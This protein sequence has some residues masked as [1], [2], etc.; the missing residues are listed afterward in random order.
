[1][2]KLEETSVFLGKKLGNQD[3][4][5]RAP[6]EIIAKE[7]EKYDDCIKKMERLKENLQKMLDLKGG[8]P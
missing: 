3:F 2:T 8:Q 6:G 4:I 1:M 7:K 5:S